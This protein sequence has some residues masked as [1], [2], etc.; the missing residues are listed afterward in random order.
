MDNHTVAGYEDIAD[1]PFL[2]LR[3]KTAALHETYNF[4]KACVNFAHFDLFPSE[5]DSSEPNEEGKYEW[6]DK[7]FDLYPRENIKYHPD[8]TVEL[9][10][11]LEERAKNASLIS[12]S[13]G[14][15]MIQITNLSGSAITLEDQHCLLEP[16]QTFEFTDPVFE[17][18]LN[19]LDANG[20]VTIICDAVEMPQLKLGVNELDLGEP[21][22]PKFLQ[23]SVYYEL[24]KNFQTNSL[25][26]VMNRSHH[27]DHVTPF[28]E[29]D[30]KGNI[31]EKLWWQISFDK[32]FEF[33]IPNFEGI[34]DFENN[35]SLDACTDTFFNPRE[36]YY[37]RAK[38][39]QNGQWSEWSSVFDF[40]VSKPEQIQNPQ[41]KKLGDG[42]YQ[43]SWESANEKETQYHI[44]A[45]NAYDFMPSIY[46]NQQYSLIDQDSEISEQV[47][48][49]IATTAEC[50]LDIGTQYAFYRVVAE[51]HGQYAVP[52]PIIHVYDYSLSIPRSVMQ[53]SSSKSNTYLA[54]RQAFPKAYPN[55]DKDYSLDIQDHALDISLFNKKYYAPSPYVSP[56]IWETVKPYFLPENHPVKAKLDRLFSKRVTQTS[57]SLKKA[58]FTQPDPRRFSK[59]IVTKNKNVPGYIFKFYSD[60]QKG[61]ADWLLLLNRVTGAIY[62][63]D[64]LNRYNINHLFAV[65]TK[66]IYPLPSDTSPPATMQRKNFIVVENAIDL[67]SKKEN[68]K[69]WKDITIINP[70]TLAWIYRLLQDLGLSDSPYNFNMPIAKDHRITF[71]DT[72]HHHKWPVPHH[73]LWPFLS[74]EMGACWNSI[75]ERDGA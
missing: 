17:I 57:N 24:V 56:V 40:C 11:N 4:A 27:F 3:T 13:S 28:F 23:L 70:N 39:S 38:A 59:T 75:C 5:F 72:E 21:T 6:K 26:K 63:Q 19:V 7:K 34:Q 58:G 9:T 64:A 22:D 47:N 54:E 55:L 74:P 29:L 43:I 71:I 32:D 49:L 42:Q 15:P 62:I 31:P 14:F 68:N 12:I 25:V 51:R 33:I 36:I 61:L 73:K 1:E 46:T 37:F 69:M 2:A 53:T 52:S 67:Y 8:S 18:N 30:C 50:S 41:F 48:N 45:S 60:E 66:W 16:H 44:F 10:I 35:I 65:P 20:K